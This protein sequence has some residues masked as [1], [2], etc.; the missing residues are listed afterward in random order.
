MNV[1]WYINEMK[2]ETSVRSKRTCQGKNYTNSIF[3]NLTNFLFAEVS[4][5]RP[6]KRVSILYGTQLLGTKICLFSGSFDNIPIIN[7]KNTVRECQSDREHDQ[8]YKHYWNF[9]DVLHV[10][11]WF[12]M[13]LLS[14]AMGI[15][16]F[17]H[18]TI[19]KEP[20]L[21]LTLSQWT[22]KKFTFY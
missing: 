16:T 4:Q 21:K 22:I 19:F 1:V 9:I 10:F 15:K 6:S 5:S 3:H 2:R 12:D 18:Y 20:T 8:G 14:F 11:L 17:C 7:L 13:G